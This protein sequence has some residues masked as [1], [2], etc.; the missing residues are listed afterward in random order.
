MG[1]CNCPPPMSSSKKQRS[2]LRKA[3]HRWC[4]RERLLKGLVSLSVCAL[5]I[6]SA[7]AM[8]FIITTAWNYLALIHIAS[9]FFPLTPCIPLPPI[10]L[11]FV[12][13]LL[14]KFLPPHVCEHLTQHIRILLMG[15]WR[16]GELLYYTLQSR[17]FRLQWLLRT[18]CPNQRC[19][20]A[21]LLVQIL[22]GEVAE[23]RLPFTWPQ[24]A[25]LKGCTLI[26]NMFIQ[27]S[28]ELDI[29]LNAR[30]NSDGETA[31]H[32]ACKYGQYNITKLR[33]ILFCKI[34]EL[35]IL[36]AL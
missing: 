13:H 20:K 32:I 12:P 21:L 4:R 23:T 36:Y 27:K 16:A 31:F 10:N 6:W 11:P 24:W 25:C 2:R 29:N 9:L 15:T 18:R 28:V 34:Y 8:L 5:P 30:G 17:Q 7:N 33:F 22:Y 3:S 1:H 14:Q 19:R 26:A 35:F